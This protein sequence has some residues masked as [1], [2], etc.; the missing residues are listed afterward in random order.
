VIKSRSIWLDANSRRTVRDAHGRL[1]LCY[2]TPNWAAFVSL[3]VTESR[4]YGASNMQ[5][6]RRLQAMLAHLL[7]VMPEA[8]KAVPQQELS[9]LHRAIQRIFPDDEDRAHAQVGDLQGIGSSE[10]S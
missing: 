3:A 4:H 7:R 6:A 9:L 1:R 5:V 10:P 2:G 8:R